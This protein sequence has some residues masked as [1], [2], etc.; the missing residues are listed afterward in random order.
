MTRALKETDLKVRFAERD[1]RAKVASNA[2]SL[3]RAQE[4]LGHADAEITKRIYVR[5]AQ[6]VRPAKRF[7]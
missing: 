3:K 2:D 5:K 6:L 7:E 1:I 4:I